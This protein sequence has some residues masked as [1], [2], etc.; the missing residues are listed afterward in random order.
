MAEENIPSIYE[1]LHQKLG[2]FPVGDFVR[3]YAKAYFEADVETI[4]KLRELLG[5]SSKYIE[6][7]DRG[8]PDARIGAPILT[9]PNL[10]SG[11]IAF[12]LPNDPEPD[13]S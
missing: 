9:L 6:P 1:G 5:L 2:S 7:E 11:A 10:N 12:P 13:N 8:E 4:K 3:A